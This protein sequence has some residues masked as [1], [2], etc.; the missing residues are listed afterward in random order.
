MEKGL[1]EKKGDKKEYGERN[2]RAA[3]EFSSSVL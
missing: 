1:R 3:L 2:G